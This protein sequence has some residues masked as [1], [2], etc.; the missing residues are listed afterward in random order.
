M[1]TWIRI[2]S[3]PKSE[4]LHSFYVGYLD[5]VGISDR[6][7]SFEIDESTTFADLREMV[8]WRQK[9]GCYFRTRLYCEL[10]DTM[11]SSSNKYGYS[12]ANRHEFCFGYLADKHTFQNHNDSN[13]KEK[14]QT[15]QSSLPRLIQADIENEP[16]DQIIAPGVDLILVPKILIPK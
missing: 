11:R 4:V 1:K 13:R 5:G 6:I 9:D 16:I 14:N 10:L 2:Y 15:F 8:S 12:K 3:E 7:A